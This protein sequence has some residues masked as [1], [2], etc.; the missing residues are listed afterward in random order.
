VCHLT[1]AEPQG[2][3]HAV[4]VLDEP[5]DLLGLEGQVVLV[6]LRAKTDLFHEYDLLV[7]ARFA[8][9]FFLLV[10]EAPVV[11]HAAHRRN[12]VRR[13]LDEV[14]PPISRS[15]QR[16]KGWQ[17]AELLAILPDESYF[18]NANLLVDA[19]VSADAF[20]PIAWA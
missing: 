6:R 18:A 5:L 1:P 16:L 12:G 11:E 19:Q 13:D 20:L 3:F 10:L 9:L 7:L 2:H 14:D 15:L 17:D 4:A 8:I